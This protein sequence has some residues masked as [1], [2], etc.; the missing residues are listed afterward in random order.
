[1]RRR[2]PKYQSALSK[3]SPELCDKLGFSVA[4]LMTTDGQ[5]HTA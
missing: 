4:F 5:L 3:H 2:L 1:M